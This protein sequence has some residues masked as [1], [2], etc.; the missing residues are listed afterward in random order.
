[1]LEARPEVLNHNLETVPSLYSTV[2]PQ[3]DYQQSLQ[4]LHRSKKFAPEV[5]S[6]CGIMVGLGERREELRALMRDLRQVGC[7]ILTM[8]QYLQPSKKHLPVVRYVPPE[9]F[10]ELEQEALAL[11]FG[12]VAAAPFVRSS[13][14]AEALFRRALEMSATGR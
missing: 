11:G 1:V 7:D 10:A 14:Q 13:Y 6:K 9:E 12:A 8:G 4:V 3:A 5:V 2:R